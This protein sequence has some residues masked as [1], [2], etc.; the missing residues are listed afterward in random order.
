MKLVDQNEVP[1]K[2]LRFISE[3]RLRCAKEFCADLIEMCNSGASPQ[4]WIV[5]VVPLPKMNSFEMWERFASKRKDPTTEELFAVFGSGEV[6]VGM[7]TLEMLDFPTLS[8]SGFC[9]IREVAGIERPLIPFIKMV[10]QIAYD[11]AQRLTLDAKMTSDPKL[12]KA[13]QAWL[14]EGNT[15]VPQGKTIVLD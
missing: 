10:R 11:E 4:G 3:S 5:S 12:F 13:Y 8:Y 9:G 15:C 6:I 14:N 1:V 2:E 7:L